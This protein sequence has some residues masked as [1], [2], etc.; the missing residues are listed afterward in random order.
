MASFPSSKSARK[1]SD[2]AGSYENHT[3]IHA[4][5]RER[6]RAINL[7]GRA[8][9][10]TQN[11]RPPKRVQAWDTALYNTDHSTTEDKP[12]AFEEVDDD[13]GVKNFYNEME[14]AE[15]PPDYFQDIVVPVE[16][17]YYYF[18]DTLIVAFWWHYVWC[19]FL[20]FKVGG[21][22]E[23]TG[24]WSWYINFY[25]YDLH[26]DHNLHFY[27]YYYDLHFDHNLHFYFYYYYDLHFD[28]NLHFYFYYYFT[29]LLL[30]IL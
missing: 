20:R 12:P 3:S 24:R 18:G 25:F 11:A 6:G 27:F 16:E 15:A 10:L 21:Q 13:V 9:K 7:N 28:H 4:Q 26:F 22:Y 19:D 23:P 14:Y 30:N 2:V 8:G 1:I 5:E 29:R 17:T